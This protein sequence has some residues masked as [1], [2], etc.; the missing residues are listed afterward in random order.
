MVWGC[1]NNEN[2]GKLT[3]IDGVL[4][5]AKYIN[6]LEENLFPS[7]E[8]FRLNNKFIFQ[9]DNDP[10]HTAKIVQNFIGE[11][12]ISLLSWPPQSPDLN[13]IEHLWEELK[14]QI[15]KSERY[16]K[17]KFMAALQKS[18]DNIKPSI[19]K[20]LIRSMPNRLQEVIKAKGYQTSY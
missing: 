9:H 8:K 16:S 20:K 19:L 17:T 13:P 1:F 2:L 4:T 7:I 11:K 15:P 12:N 14:R 5:A 6:I 18:W 10:K 3:F